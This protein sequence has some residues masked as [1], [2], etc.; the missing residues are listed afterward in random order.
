MKLTKEYKI[1]VNKNQLHGALE[2][3]R[4]KYE[5]AN[6]YLRELE[7]ALN[8]AERCLEELEEIVSN[9]NKQKSNTFHGKE[10]LK[11]PSRTGRPFYSNKITATNPNGSKAKSRKPG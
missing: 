10:S 5:M 6:T 9:S 1:L 7:D 3:I 4:D 8:N 2:K 11:I